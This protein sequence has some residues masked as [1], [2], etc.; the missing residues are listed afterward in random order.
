MIAL[1]E[2]FAWVVMCVGVAA[3]ITALILTPLKPASVPDTPVPEE[4]DNAWVMT[5]TSI[6]PT[7]VLVI[8]TYDKEIL[9]S[10][11]EIESCIKTEA[12]VQN[13]LK[14]HAFPRIKIA[15]E[16]IVAIGAWCIDPWSKPDTTHTHNRAE[17]VP[18]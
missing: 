16:D 15:S 10:T 5:L 9:T 12:V 11:V 13:A 1:K 17:G 18:Q 6:H 3:Y 7:G 14:T 2:T 8:W 4:K